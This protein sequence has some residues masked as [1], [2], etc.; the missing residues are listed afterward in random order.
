VYI[1]NRLDVFVWGWD[2]I[3]TGSAKLSLLDWVRMD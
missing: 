2:L 1:R 3:A